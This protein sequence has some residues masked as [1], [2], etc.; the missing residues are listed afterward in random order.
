MSSGPNGGASAP[1]AAAGNALV[2]V[3]NAATDAFQN[4]KEGVT[5]VVNTAAKNVAKATNAVANSVAKNVPAINS[6]I[7][8]GSPAAAGAGAGNNA[9]K[10]GAAAN[11]AGVFGSVFGSNNMKKNGVA[12]NNAPS[13]VAEGLLGSV[14]GSNNNAKK[15]AGVAPNMGASPPATFSNFSVTKSAGSMMGGGLGLFVG[16]VVV[17]LVIFAVFNEQIR[18][19]YEY[20]SVAIKQALGIE[21]RPAVASQITPAD[22]RIQELTVPPQPPQMMTPEQE[23]VSQSLVEKV[24]PTTGAG[25]EVFNVAQNDFTFYDAEPLCKALGAELA[26]YE[27]VKQA[28]NRGAD[29]CNY[30]WVKGQ[31]AIYPTQ[32]GTY[33]KLQA[34]PADEKLACGTTGING[35]FFDNPELRFGVNCYG[36]KPSQ[37]AHDEKMLMEE[38]KIP[39]SPETLKVDQLVAQFKDQADSLFVKPFSDEKWSSA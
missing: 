5:N 33:D 26:T 38:G 13:N 16:L 23:S 18:K 4:V 29:W 17:F 21:T 12:A 20:A 35:G 15:N 39:R 11:N 25:A 6:L 1:I 2:G 22:G 36:K 8:F 28:W 34:G 37:T 32:K 27:Q 14:F 3:A 9:K 24:L 10:N 31:M 7:P 30:G 19:G